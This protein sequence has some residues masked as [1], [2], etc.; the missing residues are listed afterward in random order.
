MKHIEVLATIIR[1]GDKIFATQRSY[2]EWKNWWKDRRW[3]D[4]RGGAEA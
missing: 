4:A 1:N 2:G 3:G